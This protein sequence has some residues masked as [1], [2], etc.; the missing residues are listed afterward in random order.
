M[1]ITK[2]LFVLYI[3]SSIVT[4]FQNTSAKAPPI[5]AA[6]QI[7]SDTDYCD[8]FKKLGSDKKYFYDA[9][10]M[11]TQLTCNDLGIT[12]LPE[13]IGKLKNLQSINL[14]KNLLKKLPPTIANLKQLEFLEAN[15]NVLMEFPKCIRGLTNLKSLKMDGN[16]IPSIQGRLGNLQN[17]ELLS[18]EDNIICYVSP[19]LFDLPKL[20]SISLSK[21]RIKKIPEIGNLKS[22]EFIELEENEISEIPADIM[23]CENLKK[24]SLKGNPL[25]SV[26]EELYDIKTLK[27]IGLDENPDRAIVPRKLKK[28]PTATYQNLTIDLPSCEK[29]PSENCDDDDLC[30][31][32]SGSSDK[33]ASPTP[34]KE[35][36]PFKMWTLPDGTN[37][38][39]VSNDSP[40]DSNEYTV[41]SRNE[42]FDN[43]QDSQKNFAAWKKTNAKSENKNPGID[44]AIQNLTELNE[45]CSKL[46]N[47]PTFLAGAQKK[48]TSISCHGFRSPD[49]PKEIFQLTRLERLDFSQN[50]ISKIP[51]GIENLEN[52]EELDISYNRL[53]E[54]PSE[55]CKLKNLKKLSMSRNLL[56]KFP[57]NFGNL[58]SLESLFFAENQIS[59]LPDSFGKLQN[60][61]ELHG[62]H[63]K[64]NGIPQSVTSLRNIRD[65]DLSFNMINHLPSLWRHLC[66]LTSLD[67]R[68]NR[69][70][71]IPENLKR[72]SHFS[73]FKIEIIRQSSP[74][75]PSPKSCPE[76]RGLLPLPSPSQ[77]SLRPQHTYM[78]QHTAK[79]KCPPSLEVET[80]NGGADLGSTAERLAR[81][82]AITRSQTSCNTQ[83]QTP[84]IGSMPQFTQTSTRSSEDQSTQ[85]P[86][87][88][89]LT[90]P[91]LTFGPREFCAYL[92]FSGILPELYRSVGKLVLS[93]L[94]D[95]QYLRKIKNF[96][97]LRS[98]DLSY[99]HLNRFP[100]EIFELL[101]L[102]EINISHNNI[103]VIPD[104]ICY[105]RNL[106]RLNVSNNHIAY[107]SPH[108]GYLSKLSFL[109]TSSNQLSYL[110]ET[111][112]NLK[113]LTEL[114]V[115][116]NNFPLGPFI[117]KN[118]NLFPRNLRVIDG[119]EITPIQLLPSQF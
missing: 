21:N 75:Q 105:M 85:T 39:D 24:L 74:P 48:I 112:V 84:T 95:P 101:L 109:D 55:L 83:T 87:Q 89:E 82:K 61:I 100:P 91:M 46:R 60:L 9:Q 59:E 40:L 111:I 41:I 73:N 69:I 10:N 67:L 80:E 25:S 72:H 94:G 56:V 34:T 30:S 42:L 62:K 92:S 50:N 35:D 71:F 28:P 63:N 26:P 20:K 113:C 5:S 88:P 15:N 66:Y 23:Y 106:K 53:T 16:K 107:I 103:T 47:N 57:D 45:L 81:A 29:N 32:W 2:K 64:L 86:P 108:I 78:Q 11:L 13:I 70:S 102:E 17:L 7:E 79:L 22:L 65:I 6:M 96:K 36:P 31:V 37:W 43:I 58:E 119:Q 33:T 3:I 116:D 68:G 97:N 90:Q 19:D 77:I 117:I 12:E 118:K 44:L 27:E 104:D 4:P 98:I 93:G 54:L 114:N 38:A 8:F 51:D 76:H 14:S 1:N 49:F 110:P 115:R 52:L 18:F 99:C